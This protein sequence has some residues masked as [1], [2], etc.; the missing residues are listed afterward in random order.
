IA[1]A[2]ASAV[3]TADAVVVSI[4]LS[5]RPYR[6]PSV[7]KTIN[8]ATTGAGGMDTGAAPVN[9]YV[10]IYL[11]YNPANGNSALLAANATSTVAAEVYGGANMPTGYTASALVAVLPINSS[12]QF[13][14]ALLLGRKVSFGEVSA[15]TFTT[16]STTPQALSISNIVPP[17]AK[18]VA[19]SFGSNST[20][21]TAGSEF[22]IGADANMLGRKRSYG[23]L[24][25][26][27]QS[28]WVPFAINILTQQTMYWAA[29]VSSGTPSH[30]IF[31]SEYIF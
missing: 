1:N 13:K 19:G 8:L 10:A 27:G 12:S 28:V 7:N 2:S 4:G 15:L 22:D 6:L 16:N 9:G 26:S 11:I 3:F 30:R 20:A 14:V 21:A 29:Q 23:Y 18:A 24:G 31:L 25:T 5:G 17:N